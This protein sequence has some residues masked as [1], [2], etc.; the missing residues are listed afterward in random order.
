[1][2]YKYNMLINLPISYYSASGKCGVKSKEISVGKMKR[3]EAIIKPG[4]K[5]QIFFSKTFQK[6]VGEQILDNA[7]SSTVMKLVNYFLGQ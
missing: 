5:L 6:Y 7:F 3:N 4:K 2:L 1:M